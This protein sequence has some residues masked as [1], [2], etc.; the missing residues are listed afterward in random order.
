MDEVVGGLGVPEPGVVGRD[1]PVPRAEDVDEAAEL[2]GA[3]REAVQEQQR[4]GVDR[5][6]LAVE[7]PDTADLDDAVSDGRYPH[8]R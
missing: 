8:R 7:D 1:E 6:A 2:V 4:R 3:G 5:P